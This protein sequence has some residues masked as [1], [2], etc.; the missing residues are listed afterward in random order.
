MFTSPRGT[1]YYT[2]IVPGNVEDILKP[3]ENEKGP[4]ILANKILSPF[5]SYAYRVII[6]GDIFVSK[7]NQSC[8]DVCDIK[9]KECISPDLQFLNSYKLLQNF[10]PCDT[11]GFE[12]SKELPGYIENYELYNNSCIVTEDYTFNCNGKSPVVKRLCL[13]E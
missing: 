4:Y 6:K 2:I 12:V 7:V 11:V 1:Y 13:C 9:N 5:L 10:F 3:K 8:R